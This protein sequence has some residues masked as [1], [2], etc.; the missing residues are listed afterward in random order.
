MKIDWK[1]FLLVLLITSMILDTVLI[2]HGKN[3]VS[4][5]SIGK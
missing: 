2:L 5:I 4:L 1:T 3:P